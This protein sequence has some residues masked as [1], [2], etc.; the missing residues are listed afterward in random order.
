ML[1][2][3]ASILKAEAYETRS[4]NGRGFSAVGQIPQCLLIQ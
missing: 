3:N 2:S 4:G 1:T